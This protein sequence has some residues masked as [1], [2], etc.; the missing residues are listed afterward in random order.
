MKE[1]ANTGL[2]VSVHH[3]EDTFANLEVFD[4]SKKGQTKKIYSF[5]GVSDRGIFNS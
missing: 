5:E 1:I 4:V 3:S 2:L